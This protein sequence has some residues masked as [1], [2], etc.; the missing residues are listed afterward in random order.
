MDLQKCSHFY[1]TKGAKRTTHIH[2]A[3]QQSWADGW[4][5]VFPCVGKFIIHWHSKLDYPR[6]KDLWDD[7]IKHN[8][9][10]H[11]KDTWTAKMLQ[12]EGD[13]L[14]T[15]MCLDRIL[16]EDIFQESQYQSLKGYYDYMSGWLLDKYLSPKSLRNVWSILYTSLAQSVSVSG[17][18]NTLFLGSLEKVCSIK[19]LKSKCKQ[20]GCLCFLVVV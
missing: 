5:G 1:R 20:S 15:P 13:V 8:T 9:E 2:G 12:G 17:I 6:V 3:L 19:S 7:G 4:I 14:S 16:T 18:L 11:E 10:I